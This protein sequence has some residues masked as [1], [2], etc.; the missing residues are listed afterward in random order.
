MTGFYVLSYQVYLALPMQA[1]NIVTTDDGA[2]VLVAVVFA[3]SGGITIAGQLRVTAWCRAR[4]GA[5]RAL[6]RGLAVLG[7]GFVP[8]VLA[9]LAAVLAP[10]PPRSGWGTVI[11]VVA[12]LATATLLAL[13]TAVVAP[14]EMDTIVVL[15]RD[16]LVATHY[17]LYN[18]VCGAGIL[19][20]NLGTG[21]AL[22]LARSLDV[23][24]VP[25]AALLAVGLLSSAAL[26]A[27]DRR[28]LLVADRT[29][30][31][32]SAPPESLTRAPRLRPCPA[33]ATTERAAQPRTP[34][35]ARREPPTDPLWVVPTRAWSWF[36]EPPARPRPAPRRARVADDVGGPIAPSLRGSGIDK[37]TVGHGRGDPACR[38]RTGVAAGSGE[39]RSGPVR[40]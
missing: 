16:R 5:G 21:W 4:W 12:L 18:T 17:G 33:E 24:Y 8:M 40:P 35:A 27:L 13:G 11:G 7:I 1:R 14:F 15:S 28:G 39:G 30:K 6:G 9:D 38:C 37:Y 25:W 20:G 31:V 23:P 10:Q 2:T 34:D 36:D 22:D 3:V 19:L 29:S 26:S 32:A